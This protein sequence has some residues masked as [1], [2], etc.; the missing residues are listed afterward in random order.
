MFNLRLQTKTS[1]LAFYLMFLGIT[2]NS[3]IHAG[4]DYL[5]IADHNLVNASSLQNLANFHTGQGLTVSLVD[6]TT[7]GAEP[8]KIKAYINSVYTSTTPR[9]LD[10]VLLIG[11]TLSIPYKTNVFNGDPSEAWYAWLDG[12][13]KFADIGLGRLPARNLTDLDQMITKTLNFHNNVNPGAWKNRALLVAAGE[14]SFVENSEFIR[15]HVFQTPPPN[16]ITLYGN[17]PSNYTNTDITNAINNG[18]LIVSYRGHGSPDSWAGWNQSGERYTNTDVAALNNGTKTPIIF[19]LSCDNLNM[20]YQNSLGEAFVRQAQGAVG[21]IGSLRYSN[22]SGNQLISSQLFNG[23]WDYGVNSLGYLNNWSLKQAALGVISGSVDQNAVISAVLG[24]PSIQLYDG[25]KIMVWESK[26]DDDEVGGSFGNGDHIIDAGETLE[27]T[28]YLLN[29]FNRKVNAINGTLTTSDPYVSINSAP[30][31]FGNAGRAERLGNASPFILVVSPN[32]PNGHK[33]ASTLT[34]TGTPNGQLPG[35]WSLPL[36]FK[37]KREAIAIGTPTNIDVTLSPGESK[38]VLLTLKNNGSADLNYSIAELAGE[39]NP[40]SMCPNR[41]YRVAIFRHTDLSTVSYFP[42]EVMNCFWEHYKQILESDPQGR[43]TVSI[44]DNLNSSTLSGFDRLVLPGNAVP[45]AYLENVEN[46]LTP[47]KRLIAVN[48]AISYVAYSG[49][50][51]PDSRGW[52]GQSSRFVNGIETPILWHISNPGTAGQ[53]I[54]TL[55]KA[56]EGYNLTDILET[57]EIRPNT[58]PTPYIIRDR[59]PND[60]IALTEWNYDLGKLFATER[61]IPG[62]GTMVILGAF[63]TVFADAIPL[64]RNAI[65]GEGNLTWLSTNMQSGTINSHSQENLAVTINSA[66]AA[67]GKYLGYLRVY[68]NATHP[69]LFVPVNMTISASPNTTV[70]VL[71][72]WLTGTNHAKEAGSSRALIVNVYGENAST[73]LAIASVK[74]GGQTMTK[75]IEKN[76]GTGTR[77]YAGSFIL[78]EAGIAAATSGAIAVTWASVPS[79]GSSVMSA[80]L[81]NVNQTTLIG[82][83]ATG[84]A[85]LAATVSTSALANAAGDMVFVAATAANNNIYTLGNGF[86]R[87]GA[88]QAPTWGDITAGF[89]SATGIAETPSVTSGTSQRQAIIGFV[90]K[91]GGAPVTTYTISATAGINGSISPSGNVSVVQGASQ[92]FSII[93]NSG[94]VVDNVTVNGISQGS[95]SSYTFT[96]VTANHTISATFKS[97]PSANVSILGSWVQGTTRVKEAGTSRA[98]VVMLYGEGTGDISAAT[99]T[100]GG[101]SMTKVVEKS[102]SNGTYSYTGAFILSESG[103]AAATTSNIAVT[104]SKVPSAGSEVVSVFLSNVN[105]TSLVGS[106]GTG[107]LVGTTVTASA[108]SNVAGD[109]VLIAGTAGMNGVYSINNGFTRGIAETSASFGDITTAFKPAT[110]AAETPSLSQSTSQRQ[111][112]LGFVVKK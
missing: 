45:D 21:F 103:V 13:D 44:I 107:S 47:D 111:T 65:E 49:L 67:A 77:S 29:T 86:S 69:P 1:A 106:S 64:V 87:A 37:V 54:L 41:P 104:W 59:A 75:V 81:S 58:N 22:S 74:Y 48:Y 100:Y 35:S 101:Q 60:I 57:I 26:I 63:D 9:D 12:D 105:Q 112:I 56:T 99:V 27:L 110:G 2:S 92:T 14:G 17:D 61:K 40:L 28:T 18:N 51:W 70:A 32:C 93:P 39:K 33:V 108:L 10:Y 4:I 102:F 8:D 89:K 20:D 94:M 36:E 84:G 90:V 72:S 38:T 79:S 15:T 55:E 97:A 62:K 7:I 52:N 19:S 71:G 95:I 16:F 85:D 82:A 3:V 78:N 88:E 91:A 50:F 109:M 80:F 24:D 43:F 96:N 46:W 53:R 83:T 23:A 68:S 42:S 25:N 76:Q 34:V 31:S 98:L 11:S 66:G 6:V 73:N 30:V 5:I